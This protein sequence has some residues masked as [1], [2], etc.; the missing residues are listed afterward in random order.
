MRMKKKMFISIIC[1]D[2]T[3][4]NDGDMTYQ[5]L[6]RRHSTLAYGLRNEKS[7]QSKY[8]L[9]NFDI[10]FQGNIAV[11]QNSLKL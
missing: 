7:N 10:N 3:E 8:T 4:K 9:K 1:I 6:L 2:K 5:F 11:S